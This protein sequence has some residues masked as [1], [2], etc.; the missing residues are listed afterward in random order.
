[1]S[2]S[3]ISWAICKSAIRSRQ[4]TMPVPRHSVF[5]RL[6]ALHAAKPT[7]SKHWRQISHSST[8]HKC[9]HLKNGVKDQTQMHTTFC[10]NDCCLCCLAIQV[11]HTI[12]SAWNVTRRQALVDAVHIEMQVAVLI[13]NHSHSITGLH[14][15]WH[16][17]HLDYIYIDS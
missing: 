9:H 4:I 2:G 10:I 17:N 7:A 5:Y 13:S 12:D 6:D 1:M 11:N 8:K 16:I 15:T 3:G 14:I